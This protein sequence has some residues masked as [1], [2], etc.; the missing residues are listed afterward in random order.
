MTSKRISLDPLTGIEQIFHD[1][2]DIDGYSIETRQDLDPLIKENKEFQNHGNGG[3]TPSKDMKHVASVPFIVLEIWA[4]E[5]GLSMSDPGF[6]EVVKRKLNDPDMKY[7][8]TG[9][10]KL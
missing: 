2:P 10:G 1:R 3:W 9:T 5:S 7:L 8:R 4:Q 6:D